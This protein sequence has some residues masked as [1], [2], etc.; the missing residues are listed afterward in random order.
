[1][2][3]KFYY[4]F[5]IILFIGFKIFAQ[6]TEGYENFQKGKALYDKRLYLSAK[7]TLKLALNQSKKMNS[8]T[9]TE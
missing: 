7:T 3:A 5:L 8:T 4:T 1:M 9:K 6:G 2:K